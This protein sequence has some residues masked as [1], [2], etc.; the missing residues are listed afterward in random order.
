M[1]MTG[2]DWQNF[3]VKNRFKTASKPKLTKNFYELASWAQNMPVVGL[4]EVGRGCL[5]GPVVTAA[6]MLPIGKAHRQLKDSKVM[7][8]Q[9]R[10]T[11]YRWITQNCH[12][13]IGM[14]H[15]RLIDER[16]IWQANLVAMQKALLNLLATTSMRPA[17]I[18]TDAVP[19]KIFDTAYHDIP[20][21]SFPKGERYS[22]SI[23]AASII[24]KVTRDTLM[25]KLDKVFPGYELAQHK[26]YCTAVHQSAVRELGPSIIHRMTF[27][28]NLMAHQ[29]TETQGNLFT[30]LEENP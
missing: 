1:E 27:L 5:A 26:G 14:A 13:G 21:H 20:I 10:A 15:H 25:E 19:L 6:V 4:D 9:E 12:F 8:P 2:H 11:A 28:Q 7:T 29:S 3:M 16:N 24:A 18:L 17:A 22:S 23:A 30:T